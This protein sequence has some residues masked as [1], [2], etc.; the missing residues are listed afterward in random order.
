MKLP[1]LAYCHQHPEPVAN[2][3]A[4]RARDLTLR[5]SGTETAALSS[6]THDIQ[7][8]ARVALVGPNG[9][10]KSTLIKAIAGLLPVAQGELGVFGWPAGTCRHRVAYLPQRPSIDWRFPVNVRRL[11][12]AGR[13]VHLGWMR[14]P[15]AADHAHV[16]RVL[17]EVGLY[18]VR[19]RQIGELS[20]GQQQRALLARALVQGADLLL[21]DEPLNHVDAATSDEVNLVLDQL[22]NQ[23][24]TIVVSTHDPSEFEAGFDDMICLKDGVPVPVEGRSFQELREEV[25]AG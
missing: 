18:P 10:G 24:K 20:G 4:V 14:R 11:V 13:Y 21:L 8:G 19:D 17:N 22:R 15:G 23:G 5:Y 16:D 3:P 9:S 1:V 2:A 25:W 7:V 12:L 6:L